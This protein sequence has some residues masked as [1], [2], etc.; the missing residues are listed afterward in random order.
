[1]KREEH[2]NS[3]YEARPETSVS[4]FEPEPVVSLDLIR[5]VLPRD[6]S[7]IDIGGASRLV[8]SLLHLT[9]GQVAVLDV[10]EVALNKAKTR[11]AAWAEGV[12]WITG[13]VTTL[14]DLGQFDVWHDRA[15]FHFLTDSADRRRYAALAAQTVRR[16]GHAIIGTFAHDGPR[17][18]SG[19]E[20]CRYDAAGLAHELGPSF[21]LLRE[22]AQRHLTPAGETQ[23]FCWVVCMKIRDRQS[24]CEFNP[25][26][27]SAQ[28]TRHLA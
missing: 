4:W 22:H 5:P 20:V 11:L 6:G 18:C 10:S 7:V 16:G 14:T 27:K 26:T 3:V 8:D 17:R 21:Q 24:F 13:D 1:M 9:S 23:S 2:W 12:R 25:K 19:L 15:V 28:S